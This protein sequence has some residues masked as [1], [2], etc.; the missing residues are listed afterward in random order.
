LTWKG[1]LRSGVPLSAVRI[2]GTL[3]QE[4]CDRELPWGNAVML[5]CLLLAVAMAELLA[6]FCFEGDVAGSRSRCSTL[7]E[8][9]PTI[10]LLDIS[11]CGAHATPINPVWN[12]VV[13]FGVQFPA[14]EQEER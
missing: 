14:P 9:A 3:T 13:R 10:L 1:P 11:G 5:R 4:R 8:T 6:S 12:G 7:I 2:G